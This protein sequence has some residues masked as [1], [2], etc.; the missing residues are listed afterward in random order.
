MSCGAAVVATNSGGNSEIIK[1]ENNSL[2]VPVAN[3]QELAK[4]VISLIENENLNKKIGR[5][6]RRAVERS[7]TSERCAKETCEIYRQM[8]Q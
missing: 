3:Y 4:S 1:H 6:A 5:E 8:I 7:F 2:L